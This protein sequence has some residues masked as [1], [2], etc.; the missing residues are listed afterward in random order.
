MNPHQRQRCCPCPPRLVGQILIEIQAARA[1]GEITELLLFH[2]HPQSAAVYQPVCK[3]LLPLDRLWQRELK[4]LVW[5]TRNLPQVLEGVNPALPA[6]IGEYLFVLLFQACAESLASENASRLASMQRAEQN[7]E[8][9]LDDLGRR[10]HRQRQESIDEEL[11]EVISGYEALS[12][13]TPHGSSGG[14]PR[15]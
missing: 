8:D 7:I 9:M 1:R 11:F 3:R 5:P 13:F 4:A 10:Y 14:Q 12:R 6:F 2:N 15:R